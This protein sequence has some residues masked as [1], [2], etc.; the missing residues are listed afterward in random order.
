M[1]DI[2]VQAITLSYVNYREYDRILTLFSPEHGLLTATAHAVRRGKS[3]IRACADLFF[4]GEFV[5]R[6]NAKGYLSVKSVDMIDVFYDLRLDINKL[7]CAMYLCDFIKG[8]THTDEPQHELFL[9]LMKSLSLLCYK[10]V[11]YKTVKLKFELGAMALI[12]YSVILDKC[13]IC[14]GEVK[15]FTMLSN[16]AGGIV[17]SACNDNNHG[18][19]ISLQAIATLKQINEM[20]IDNIGVIKISNTVFKEIDS[21]FKQYISWHIERTFKSA[22]FLENSYLFSDS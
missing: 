17:C 13:S 11:D 2:K 1:T 20:P 7:S 14:S 12:G 16:S 10:D 18:I 19:K 9:L 22:K 15:E 21:V 8:V 4:F 5:L 6:K 3:E